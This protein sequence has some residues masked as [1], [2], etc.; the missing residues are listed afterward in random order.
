MKTI[1]SFTKYEISE[2]G[3]TIIGVGRIRKILSQT[4]NKDG[5]YQLS[6]Y[7]DNTRKCV[8][9]HRLV[10]E[11]YIPNPKCLPVVNHIDGNKTNNHYSNLEWCTVGHNN[12]HAFDTGLM[13]NAKILSS[14]RGRLKP[15][16]YFS[17]MGKGNRKLS[18]EDIKT[19]R[20]LANTKQKSYKELALIYN[21]DRS[22][23]GK[24]VRL[25]RYSEIE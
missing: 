20:H 11:T 13:D 15:I 22:S 16:D 9:T 8:R 14:E 5:Y 12:Q 17:S 6:L 3:T 25:E 19:I 1:P 7:N 23:I 10:A 18:N 4:I 21:Y 24:I 2:D